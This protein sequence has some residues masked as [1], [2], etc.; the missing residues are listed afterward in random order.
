MKHPSGQQ[1][2]LRYETQTAVIT[3][4]GAGIRTYRVGSVEVLD[5]Y[6]ENEMRDGARGQT[7]LPWPN[8]VKDGRYSWNGNAHQLPLAEPESHNGV[9]QWVALGQ[10]QSWPQVLPGLRFL[11]PVALSR[12]YRGRAGHRDYGSLRDKLRAAG[13]REGHGPRP[14]GRLRLHR[15]FLDQSGLA[16]SRGRT[17]P[18]PGLSGHGR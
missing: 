12:F 18:W 16:Q 14:R 2:V 8:R 15:C 1:F 6:A 10:F 9:C 5:G 11:S 17:Q 13:R 4:V 3:E 7:L